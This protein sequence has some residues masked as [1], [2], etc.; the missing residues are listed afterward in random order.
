MADSVVVGYEPL[1]NHGSAGPAPTGAVCHANAP[2]FAAVS[3]LDEDVALLAAPISAEAPYP[4]AHNWPT[5]TESPGSVGSVRS[6]SL[7]TGEDVVLPVELPANLQE[8]VL[9]T[10]PLLAP[11][12]SV[13]VAPTARPLG[14]DYFAIAEVLRIAG[15]L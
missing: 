15:H 14:Q 11:R 3:R 4:V 1:R 2:W 9:L 5:P 13:H 7:P 12:V 8:G 6:A 10:V